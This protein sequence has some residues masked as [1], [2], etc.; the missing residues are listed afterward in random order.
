MNEIVPPDVA[1]HLLDGEVL[2]W[3]DM[4]EPPLAASRRI[5]A[6]FFVGAVFFVLPIVLGAKAANT[7][8]FGGLALASFSVVGLWLLSAPLRAYRNARKTY[9]ALTDRRALILAGATSKTFLLERVAFV[10]A[11]AND[12]GKGHVLFYRKPH[13]DKDDVRPKDVGFEGVKAPDRVAAT[14]LGLIE[15]RR[16]RLGTAP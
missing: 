15:A 14:M 13:Y 16:S 11:E 5:D 2:V 10:E 12:S 8:Y 1:G 7:S 3:W 9:Y 6:H 4:P